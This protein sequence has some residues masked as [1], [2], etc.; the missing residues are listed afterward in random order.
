MAVVVVVVLNVG[1]GR[2]LFCCCYDVEGVIALSIALPSIIFPANFFLIFL[3]PLKCFCFFVSGNSCGYGWR[4]E[5]EGLLRL[6]R[7]L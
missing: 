7:M 3:L 5:E 6:D 2:E 4:Y 1:Y